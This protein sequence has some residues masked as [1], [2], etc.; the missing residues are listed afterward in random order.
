MLIKTHECSC[1]LLDA[2]NPMQVSFTLLC[3]DLNQPCV[4]AVIVV[5]L[6]EMPFKDTADYPEKQQV[7]VAAGGR[8]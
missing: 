2:T 8:R 3:L 1:K 4:I 7:R 5:L 6:Q